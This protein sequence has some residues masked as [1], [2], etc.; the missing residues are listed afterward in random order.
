VKVLVRDVTLLLLGDSLV[1]VTRHATRERLLASSLLVVVR[2]SL[3]GDNRVK[4]C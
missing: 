2:S 1:K 3:R 4:I